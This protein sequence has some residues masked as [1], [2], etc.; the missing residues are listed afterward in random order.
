MAGLQAV[1]ISMR[2]FLASVGT[3][4]ITQMVIDSKNIPLD[5]QCEKRA[6]FFGV[7]RLKQT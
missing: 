7:Q 3:D 4:D 1:A 2:F 5:G 6:Y